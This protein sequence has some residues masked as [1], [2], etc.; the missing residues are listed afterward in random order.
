M[1]QNEIRKFLKSVC[2][3]VAMKVSDVVRKYRKELDTLYA[4]GELSQVIFMVFEHV[5]TFSKVDLILKKDEVVSQNEQEEFEHVLSQLKANKPIQYVLGYAWFYGLKFKVNENVLIPRQET[6]ELVEWILNES[7]ERTDKIK[8]LDIC[9]G[10]G[11]MA[12]ALK[13]KLPGADVSALD[14][15]GKAL[16]VARENATMNSTSIQFFQSDIL[17]SQTLNSELRTEFDLIVSNP[18]YVLESEKSQMQK[19]ELDYEP[20]LAMFVKDNDPLIFYK[21]IADIALINLNSGGKLYFEINERNG[22]EVV[23]LL[24]EKGFSEVLLKKD[25]NG[26]DRMV[27]AKL[28]IRDLKSEN[29]N[30]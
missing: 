5:K 15:S 16:G 4:E 24:V 22:K 2:S 17:Q 7:Q 27:S 18:P 19:K 23:E 28:E 13:N 3:F 6:E 29:R 1:I 9:T 12:I 21:R 20:H 10:S 25:L 30:Q 14:V 8:I 26:K 11:C